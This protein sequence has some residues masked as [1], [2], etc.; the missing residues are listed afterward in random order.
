MMAG[1][2]KKQKLRVLALRTLGE[3]NLDAC[4][5][6]SFTKYACKVCA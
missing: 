5:L 6:L 3:F 2:E 4:H 1:L